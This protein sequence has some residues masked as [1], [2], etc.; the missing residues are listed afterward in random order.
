[1]ARLGSENLY[2]KLSKAKN[3]GMSQQILG[4]LNPLLALIFGLAFIV[5]WLIQKQRAYIL[6]IA[7]AYFAFA[8]GMFV[9]NIGISAK[10]IFHVVGTHIFYSI[11]M[12]V[13]VKAVSARI[14]VSPRAGMNLA[15]VIGAT[16]I[17]IWLHSTSD[18]ANLR[19][20]MANVAYSAVL[21]IGAHNLSKNRS[22]GRLEYWL[23]VLFIL[24]A[25]Q[26]LIRPITSFWLEG[27]VTNADY[28]DSIY[29][30]TLNLSMSVLSLLL[31]LSLLAICGYDYLKDS[32]AGFGEH[33]EDDS[34]RTRDQNVDRLAQVMATN[35]HRNQD[36]TV[37]NLAYETGIQ[38]HILRK[39][40]NKQL[41]YKNFRDYVNSHRIKEAK[42]MLVDPELSADSITQIAFDCGFN[43]IPS[44]N[45]VFK[46]EVGMTPSDY[47]DQMKT[48]TDHEI[49]DQEL[50]KI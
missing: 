16:P 36:L 30:S 29:Y 34:A 14:H 7:F 23:F 32:Q 20:I 11:A 15:L 13:L 31:A 3:S 27:A 33:R 28:R 37:K 38:M 1:M 48:K 35:I 50:L 41:G 10:S 43:S 40:I 44:F 42:H 12:V 21:L 26:G 45:R 19:V 25:I 5:F 2:L 47:R 39:I 17:I 24:L 46:T 49:T 6:H 4:F 22:Q 18:L 9:S 8:C